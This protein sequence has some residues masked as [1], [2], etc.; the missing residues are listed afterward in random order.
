[1]DGTELTARMDPTGVCR[2][3]DCESQFTQ[4]VMSRSRMPL[5]FWIIEVVA[6][7]GLGGGI[8]LDTNALFYGFWFAV[9]A[10][11]PL[12]L[13]LKGSD[14]RLYQLGLVTFVFAAF[15]AMLAFRFFS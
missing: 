9:V 4:N 6:L 3:V 13:F 5:L 14:P 2:I 11:V 10:L 1:M 12:S 15:Y 7:M 8:N